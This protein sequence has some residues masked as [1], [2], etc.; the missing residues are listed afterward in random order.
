MR[1]SKKNSRGVGRLFEFVGG[2]EG[3]R[4]IFGNFIMQFK[5][6]L[7]LQGGGGGSD[8]PDLPLDPSMK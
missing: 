2:R 6:I 7:I 4:H 1:G 5:E 8:P 3:P